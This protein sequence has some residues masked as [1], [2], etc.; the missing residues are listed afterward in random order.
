MICGCGGLF[1][2]VAVD[3][4]SEGLSGKEKLNYISKKNSP[5]ALEVTMG[6][7]ST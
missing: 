7:R 4:Y 5:L 6:G 2:V 1:L 3:E